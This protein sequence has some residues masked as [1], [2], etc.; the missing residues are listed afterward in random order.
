MSVARNSH[1]ATLLNDGKVLVAGGANE[2]GHLASVELYDPA[3]STKYKEG[4]WLYQ[5]NNDLRTAIAQALISAEM[6][7]GYT[8]VL[9][10]DVTIDGD[11]AY[12]PVG[13]SEENAIVPGEPILI[14]VYSSTKERTSSIIEP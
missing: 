5:Y 7:T 14:V 3:T 10:D 6:A 11:W 1:S 4:T 8:Y 12:A 2:S 9:L 13:V